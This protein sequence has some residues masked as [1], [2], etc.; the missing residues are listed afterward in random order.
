MHAMRGMSQA[1]FDELRLEITSMGRGLL[2]VS[3]SHHV[4]IIHVS[5]VHSI[6]YSEA[7]NCVVYARAL[8]GQYN[9]VLVVV[10]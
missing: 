10:V 8:Y 7:L 5:L 4:S 3:L 6:G 9:T 2:H 1:D